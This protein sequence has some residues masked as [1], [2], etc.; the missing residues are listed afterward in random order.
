MILGITLTFTLENTC[1]KENFDLIIYLLNFLDPPK[2]TMYIH[3]V[4]RM[5]LQYFQGEKK[6]N[7]FKVWTNFSFLNIL[8]ESSPIFQILKI[9]S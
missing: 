4:W 2:C 7:Y 8:F 6:E 1:Q 9:P 3:S 5:A